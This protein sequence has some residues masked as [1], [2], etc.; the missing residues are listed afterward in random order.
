VPVVLATSLRQGERSRAIPPASI[1]PSAVNMP[2]TTPSAPS[3]LAVSISARM[4][5]FIVIENEITA[6]W[7]NH[8]GEVNS[9]DRSRLSD[10]ASARCDAALQ[11]I[12]A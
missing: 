6:A 12:S 4:C 11:Q 2:M 9:T 1:S 10:H 7:P 5:E 8:Y 3:T